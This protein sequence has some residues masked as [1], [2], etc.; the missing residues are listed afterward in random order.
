MRCRGGIL[1]IYSHA[2]GLMVR[3]WIKSLQNS[4]RFSS[5]KIG[6]EIDSFFGRFTFI[7]FIESDP[8]RSGPESM[9]E[10]GDLADRLDFGVKF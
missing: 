6:V 3:S 2:S 7:R 4:S 1:S 8:K 10:L 9:S 5:P